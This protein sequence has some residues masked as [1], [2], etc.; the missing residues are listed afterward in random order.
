MM[1]KSTLFILPLALFGSA[2]AQN[3]ATLPNS[4]STVKATSGKSFSG[5]ES[6]QLSNPST[7]PST[8]EAGEFAEE[9]IGDTKYDLQ[10]NS[11]LCN[12]IVNHETGISATWTMSQTGGQ[13][14]DRGTG[15][16]YWDRI[17]D[18]WGSQPTT[19]IE[20]DRNGWPSIAVN[21]DGSEHV[22]SHN[23]NT[24]NLIISSR[25]VAGTGAWTASETLLP[26][27]IADG[28][29]WPRMVAGGADGNSLH[30]L[31]ISYP[32]DPVT[33]DWILYNGQAGAIC[34]SRSTNSGASFDIVH[35]VIPAIDSTFYFGFSTDDYAID[36]NGDNVAILI[37]G[38]SAG[39][40]LLSSTDNGDN[41]TKVVVDEFPIAKYDYKTM[42]SDIDDDQI[43]DTVECND[44]SLSVL[45]DDNGTVHCFWGIT[46][47]LDDVIAEPYSYFPGWDGLA[48]W[49]TTRSVEDVDTIAFAL[50]LNGNGTLDVPTTGSPTFRFGIYSTGLTS[51]PSAGIDADG[52]LYLSYSS[53]V[54]GSDD[55]AG[56]LL[57]H[58]Y[59][60]ESGDNGDS[61]SPPVDIYEDDFSECAF[62]SMART[63][64]DCIH[65]LYQRDDQAGHSLSQDASGNQT[66][67]GNT[68]G[69]IV[70]TCVP[71]DAV[72]IQELI[73]A[74][75]ALSTFSVYPNPFQGQTQFFI[76][77]KEQTRI[78]ASVV[79]LT[80]RTVLE[81][82]SG[83]LNQ[84]R[85][86][87]VV[88][89]ESVTSGIYFVNLKLN[90]E[91]YSQ[92]VVKF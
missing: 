23:T 58:T 2:F 33:E 76:D 43:A 55:G 83:E 86:N 10:T 81:I 51:H 54:D 91:M 75:S 6:Q 61:W 92:K 64:D 11:S 15:Y 17:L 70:Y 52:V 37:G 77:L 5:N 50:D 22:I 72:G 3:R 31:S 18:Q 56:R 80:G 8:A 44:G 89:M 9:I 62:A 84:G 63:V 79:D 29:Y 74:S 42:I 41:W 90:D 38:L 47:M 7:T 34:Y 13:Y 25:A 53:V 60:M 85:H 87:Y 59:V 14:V 45:I 65:I 46:R 19:R 28:N 57:R 32:S 20:S 30:V 35:E 12:R 40:T 82:V 27:V 48:Y 71:R 16:N 78:T 24:N 1:K 49:N 4:I 73:P 69:E 39:V 66:D 21:A 36:A 88:E 68:G 67:P 26:P